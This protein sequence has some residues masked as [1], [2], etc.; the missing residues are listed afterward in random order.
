MALDN[1]EARQFVNQNCM[2]LNIP[3]LEAG[4][5]GYKGQSMIIRRGI[6]RCY[7]CYPKPR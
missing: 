3:L 7:S 1:A 4:T 6:D 2:I 5:A